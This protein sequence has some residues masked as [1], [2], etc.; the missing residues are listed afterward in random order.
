MNTYKL[1]L[2]ALLSALAI[3]GRIA[4]NAIPNVQPV[5]AIVILTG[6][7]MGPL[8][9]V[10]LAALTTFL[11]NMLLGMGIWYIWQVTAW[12]LIGAAAGLI[13]KYFS[14]IPKWGL[15]LFSGVSGLI[16]GLIISLTMYSYAGSFWAYYL[17]GLPFDLYHAFGNIVF[18]TL[19]LPVFSRL[20]ERYSRHALA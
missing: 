8:A 3:A 12:A 7:F 16:Y 15:A 17:A 6:F 10:L 5:T 14:T 18:I 13:G 20:F 9:A 2:I 11:S 19:L 4:T 1:T